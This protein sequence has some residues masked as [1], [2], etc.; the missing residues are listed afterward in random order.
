MSVYDLGEDEQMRLAIQRSMNDESDPELT[1]ADPASQDRP[2]TAPRP[3]SSASSRPGGAAASSGS[4]VSASR[5]SAPELTG[6][7]GGGGPPRTQF[8]SDPEVALPTPSESGAGPSSYVG[9][10]ELMNEPGLSSVADE[11]GGGG[12]MGG[13]RPLMPPASPTTTPV[14]MP[15]VHAELSLPPEQAHHPGWSGGAASSGVAAGAVAAAAS[16]DVD[17]EV[18]RALEFARNKQFDEAEAC[19]AAL[20]AQHPEQQKRREV[21]AAWEAVTMCKQFHAAKP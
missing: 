8:A 9:N 2:A 4:V 12:G 15:S 13:G 5:R 1:G 7:D 19:L 10:P 17:G 3:T 21:Q 16:D 11:A 6:G 20:C 14:G 18:R